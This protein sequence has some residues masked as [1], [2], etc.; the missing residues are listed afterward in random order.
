MPPLLVLLEV[1]LGDLDSI[2]RRI[3]EAHGLVGLQRC[4]EEPAGAGG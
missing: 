4:T 2:L 1:E 3:G